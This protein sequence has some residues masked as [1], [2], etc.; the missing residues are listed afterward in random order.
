MVDDKSGWVRWILGSHVQM[1]KNIWIQWEQQILEISGTNLSFREVVRSLCKSVG[2]VG[3]GEIRK[4]F[5]DVFAANR[6]GS[7][8]EAEKSLGHP[9]DTQF[10][11]DT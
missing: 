8:R 1:E 6:A 3:S 5:C 10:A 2:R 9:K 4:S 11:T 7:Y